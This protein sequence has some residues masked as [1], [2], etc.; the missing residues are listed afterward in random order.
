MVDAPVVVGSSGGGTRSG[1]R[2]RGGASP[3][4][5][6]TTSNDE[7]RRLS[8]LSEVGVHVTPPSTLVKRRLKNASKFSLLKLFANN[9]PAAGSTARPS[10]IGRAPSPLSRSVQV[11]PPSPLL[12]TRPLAA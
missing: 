8:R 7:K 1:G 11:A 2:D 12:H 3:R 9:T 4:R 6:G 5:V 10:T